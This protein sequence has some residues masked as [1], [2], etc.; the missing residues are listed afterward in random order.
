MGGDLLRFFVQAAIVAAL[1]VGAIALGVK[2]LGTTVEQ[3]EEGHHW[4]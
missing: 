1:V 3:G 4:E 2:F